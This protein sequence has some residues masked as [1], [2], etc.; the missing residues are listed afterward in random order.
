MDVEK[1]HF[2]CVVC[3]VG[4]EVDVELRDGEV[5]SMTGNKCAKGK[6]FVLQELEEPMRVL[7]TT[8]PI[9]GARWAMLPVRTDRAIA[10]RL[11]F[12]AVQELA[13][14]ELQA[15]VGVSDVIVTNIAGTGANVIATRTMKRHEDGKPA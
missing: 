8:V 10:K 13:S 5:V 15:P 11:H 3:P 14:L 4:C 6:E 7:T 2:T 1:R 9:K 12:S